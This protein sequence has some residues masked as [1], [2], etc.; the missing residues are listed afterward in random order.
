M[1]SVCSWRPTDAPRT[2]SVSGVPT[3]SSRVHGGGRRSPWRSLWAVPSR[4]SATCHPCLSHAGRGGLGEA[5]EPSEDGQAHAGCGPLGTPPAYL[6]SIAAYLWQAHGG[7]DIGP[8][9]GGVLCTRRDRAPD[10]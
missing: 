6:A 5:I 8:G 2:P 4:P 9:G 1:M 7:V 3:S 10:A